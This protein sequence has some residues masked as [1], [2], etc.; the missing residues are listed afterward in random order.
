MLSQL[1]DLSKDIYLSSIPPE[2][3]SRSALDSFNTASRKMEILCASDA[4]HLAVK[5]IW[6]FVDCAQYLQQNFNVDAV[7]K[8][9]ASI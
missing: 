1:P 8:G 6:R 2:F 5:S 9:P 4:D 3:V 7:R